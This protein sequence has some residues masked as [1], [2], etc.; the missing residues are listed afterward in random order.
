MKVGVEGIPLFG[1]RSG[2]GQYSKRL[3]EAASKLP[4]ETDFEI[5]RQLMPHRKI[6]EFPIRPNRHLT[7]R[8]VRWLPPIIYYQLFKRLGWTLPYDMVAGGK[9]DVMLF[10]NF[11]AYPTTRRARSIIVIHDLSYIFHKQYVLPKNQQYLEKFVPKSIKKADA[12]IAISENTRRE[13]SKYYNIPEKNIPIV[14]PSVDHNDYKPQSKDKIAR[15]KRKYGIDRPYIFSV[16]TIEPRKNLI[17][18]LNAFEQLPSKIKEKYSLVLVGGK[19]WLDDDIEKKYQDLARKYSVIKTGY[20]DD[21]D[22]P[23]LYSGAE[24]FV[25][26]SFYEGFGMPPLEAMACGT[27]VITSNNS[28]LPEVVGNAGIKIDAEDKDQLTHAIIRVLSDKKLSAQMSKKGVAQANNFS[29]E[30]SAKNLLS[31]IN[32]L[33]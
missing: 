12:V 15:V 28:S 11:V 10:L 9:Y 27:P 2:V 29:W 30:K 22:L 21:A 24:V 13:I 5:I 17:G 20:V 4:S 32:S 26:P 19:G 8:I 25:F 23:A 7:Y 16:G 3:V 14:N 31:V 33:S 18:I 1:N 6:S